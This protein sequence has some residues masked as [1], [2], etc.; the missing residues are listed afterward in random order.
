M[1]LI[2]DLQKWATECVTCEFNDFSVFPRWFLKEKMDSNGYLYDKYSFLIHLYTFQNY[3][4]SPYVY[5][6][7]DHPINLT[8]R[9]IAQSTSDFLQDRLF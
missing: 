9:L 1:F 8:Y 7:R 3:F 2:P 6:V 4:R 5:I